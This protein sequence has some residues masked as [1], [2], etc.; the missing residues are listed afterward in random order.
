MSILIIKKN[1]LSNSFFFFVSFKKVLI[2][3]SLLKNKNKN[4][5]IQYPF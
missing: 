3:K 5:N 1:I 4:K 2:K